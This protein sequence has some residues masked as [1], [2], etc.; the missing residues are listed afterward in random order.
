M[1]KILLSTFFIFFVQICFGQ[2]LRIITGKVID[3]NLEELPLV[4]IMINDTIKIGATDFNGNFKLQVNLNTEKLI[5]RYVGCDL[6]PVILKPDCNNL[7]I[8]MLLSPTYCFYKPKKVERLRKK[9]FQTLPLLYKS[10]Y[11]KGVFK[12]LDSCGDIQYVPIFNLDNRNK[13]SP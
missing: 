6:T 10:A 12:S 5:F 13:P 3:S 4:D 11:K 7:D 1:K 9:R 2:E 8:V